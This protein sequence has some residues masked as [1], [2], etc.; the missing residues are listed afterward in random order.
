MIGAMKLQL[1]DGLISSLSIKL[2]FGRCSGILSKF[3]RRFSEGI[4]KLAGNTS[5]DHQKKTRRLSQECYR[6]P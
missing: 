5:G 1:D 4:G 3:F 2:G 6:M